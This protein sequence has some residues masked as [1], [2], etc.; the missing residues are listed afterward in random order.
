MSQP[1]IAIVAALER[2]VRPLVRKW[3]VRERD[4][5]GR[6]FRFFE[7]DDAVVVCGG[8]GA[9][10]ARRAAEAVIAL[11]QP[12]VIYSAGYAG[13]L[14]PELKV[15]EVVE[16]RRV[17]DAG[18]GSSVSLCR[19]PHFSRK[20]RARNGAPAELR[21]AGQPRAAVPTYGLVSFG[22]VATPAQKARLRASFG[23]QAVDMEAAAVARSAQARGVGFAAVKVISEEADFVLPPVE[24]FVDSEGRFLGARFVWFAALRPWLWPRV[25]R[26]ARNSRR[27]SRVLCE[28]LKDAGGLSP[29]TGSRSGPVPGSKDP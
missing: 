26:L 21:S 11:Y 22:S 5:D 1:R 9:E 25:V 6:R 16:P 7:K 14:D 17:V 4:H 24:R 28:W 19:S 27:A 13:A 2:E 23:A 3:R 8:M 18:D 15:G 12:E 20:G 10:A 29:G